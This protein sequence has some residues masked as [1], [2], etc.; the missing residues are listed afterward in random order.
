MKEIQVSKATI[1]IAPDNA[2]SIKVY[3]EWQNE[4]VASYTLGVG[5]TSYSF[6]PDSIGVYKAVWSDSG[7]SEIQKDFYASYVPVV[8]SSEFFANYE[9]LEDFDDLYVSA[10]R[11]V[12]YIIENYTGQR[13]GPYV[14]K[15]LVVQ[16]DGGDSLVLPL[17]IMALTSVVDSWGEDVTDFM[18]IGPNHDEIIQYQPE[19]R[20]GGW[21]FDTK[22]DIFSYGSEIFSH[23]KDF[24]IT[25]DFGWEYV[26]PEVTQAAML[27]VQDALGGTEVAELRKQGVIEAQLGDF[28]VKLN[29][30]Q[31][32]TTGNVQADSL[33]GRFINYGI[34]LI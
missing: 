12:R 22:R 2:A 28:R 3:H 4:L 11:T 33:L 34:E 16:G 8:S 7:A 27:L 17:R 13:F 1:L 31:W 29:A 21:D 20:P 10:E 19:F 23:R 15:S 5:E 6:T 14:D 30:D 32:G 24:T 9:D 18:M 25:G 26:P